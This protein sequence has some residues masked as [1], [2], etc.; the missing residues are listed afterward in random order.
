MKKKIKAYIRNCEICK[1]QKHDTH[2]QK[3]TMRPTPL[4]TYVGDY[5][6]IDIFHVGKR[7]FYSTIDRFSKFVHLRET[8]NKLNAENIIEEILQIFPKFKHCMTDNEAIFTS[9]SV[10]ALFQRK[11]SHTHSHQF[12]TQQLTPKSNVSIE[13]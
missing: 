12:D 1:K 10:K 9:F 2:P 8:P 5:L 13:H 7:I 4:P 11:K 6:Q 3:H